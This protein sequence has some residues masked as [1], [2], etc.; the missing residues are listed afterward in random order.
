MKAPVPNMPEG[1]LTKQQLEQISK[2]T[3]AQSQD[4][5]HKGG[6][7]FDGGKLEFDLLPP[8]ALEETT[9]VLMIGAE[10]YE[11]D[12]WKRVPD[13]SRRYWNAAQRHLWAYKKGEILDPESGLSH[14]AHALC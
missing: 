3:L 8:Y 11:R 9:R 2:L 1:K 6:R 14:L 5:N 12:N 4:P 10:K 13:A 7:K